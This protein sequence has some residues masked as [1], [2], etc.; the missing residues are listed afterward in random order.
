MPEFTVQ[1]LVDAV[2]AG[3]EAQVRAILQSCPELVHMDMA[4]NNEHRSLHYAVLGR[5]PAMVRILMQHGADARKGIYPHRS[6]TTALT[7]A[8]ER[9]YQEIA[10]II[11][12][13]ENR[14]S[15]AESSEA[16]EDEPGPLTQA[17]LQDRPEVLE[18]LLH[19]GVDPDEPVRVRGLEQEV[20][21]RGLPLWHCARQGRYAMAETLLNRGANPN[22]QVYASGSPIFTAHGRRDFAMVDLL[23]KFGGKVGAVTAGLY[24]ETDLAREML[25]GDVDP[26]L[27]EG[28]FGGSTTAEQ[29]LWA[30]SCGGDAEITRLALERVDWPRDDK[31]WYRIMEQPVRIWNHMG[32]FWEQPSW[33]RTTYAECFRLILERCDPNVRGRFGLTMLHDVAASREHVTAEDRVQFAQMLLDAGARLDVRDELLMSTPL[34]WACRWGRPE[35]VKLLIERGADTVES[36]AEPWAT[37]LAWAEK[38]K[39]PDLVELLQGS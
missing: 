9:G 18:T 30:G 19:S 4:G 13:E 21:S 17:V 34:G 5:S 26:I 11:H 6:A 28:M 15:A 39:H 24:R 7:L 22:A 14:R 23:R 12:E 16:T 37:P 1:Q 36:D 20:F 33:D 35:L 3:D 2:R 38:R 29:L 8:T 27:E 32:G 25:A 10:A 31:R